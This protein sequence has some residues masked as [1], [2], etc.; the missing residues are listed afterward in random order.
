MSSKKGKRKTG[1]AKEPS[2][3]AKK[4]EDLSDKEW[5]ELAAKGTL[6]WRKD[7]ISSPK[8]ARA[9]LTTDAAALQ[10]QLEGMMK[11]T[12]T[13]CNILDAALLDIYTHVIW[14]AREAQLNVLQTSAFFSLVVELINNIREK[15]MPLS[16]NMEYFKQA[17]R[18][19]SVM[20]PWDGVSSIPDFDLRTISIVTEHIKTTIFQHYALYFHV[21][22]Q[23]FEPETVPFQLSYR[24]PIVPPP[25]SEAVPLPEMK[26][27][28][29]AFAHAASA[30]QHN[31]ADDSA[32]HHHDDAS[33]RAS[34]TPSRTSPHLAA[35]IQPIAEE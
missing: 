6:A 20:A 12:D 33:E 23:P 2:K 34:P 22:S 24:T 32:S 8:M 15:Q 26:A 29:P 25:L 11:L 9:L 1:S 3:L 17:M 13:H 7:L 30:T 27:N 4:Y 18:T 21:L 10:T 35:S 19:H 5:V 16:E 31:G 14:K 28:N